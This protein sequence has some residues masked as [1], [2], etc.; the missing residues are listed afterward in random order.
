MDV[1]GFIHYRIN[2]SK[3]FA[4]RQ[5]HINGIE[6]FWNQSNA[7]CEIQRNRS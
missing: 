5:N 1:S 2:H 4:D 7:S 3:E 6:N